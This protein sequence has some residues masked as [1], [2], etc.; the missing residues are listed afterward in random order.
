MYENK[1]LADKKKK[2][3]EDVRKWKKAIEEERKMLQTMYSGC[4]TSRASSTKITPFQKYLALKSNQNQQ[5]LTPLLNT[6]VCTPRMSY[7]SSLKTSRKI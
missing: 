4:F 5:S 3:K 7:A 6:A 1:C 2:M